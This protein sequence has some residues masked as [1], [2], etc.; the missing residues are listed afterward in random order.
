MAEKRKDRN[1]GGRSDNRHK[2]SERMN[3]E[4]NAGSKEQISVNRGMA[5]MDAGPSVGT[6]ESTRGSGISTKKS[7]TGS[8]YDGQLSGE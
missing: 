1:T 4:R 7:V 6:N 8:D 5:D 3:E 2:G